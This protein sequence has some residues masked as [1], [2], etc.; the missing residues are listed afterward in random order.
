MLTKLLSIYSLTGPLNLFYFLGF[1]LFLKNS[2][3]GVYNALLRTSQQLFSTFLHPRIYWKKEETGV[4]GGR[5]EDRVRTQHKKKVQDFAAGGVWIGTTQWRLA[6]WKW[7]FFESEV[8]CCVRAPADDAPI[9]FLQKKGT[10]QYSLM[11]LLL[12]FIRET[13]CAAVYSRRKSNA[14]KTKSPAKCDM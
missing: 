2:D 8:Y 9:P 12:D 4:T 11:L 13:M 14:G 3:V 6:K 1:L 5:K 7:H 10:L